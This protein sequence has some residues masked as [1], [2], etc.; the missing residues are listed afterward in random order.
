MI[1]FTGNSLFTKTICLYSLL[2]EEQ[3]TIFVTLQ[4]RRRSLSIKLSIITLSSLA[5][6]L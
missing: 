3:N 6:L 5:Q 2:K 1:G 4:Y